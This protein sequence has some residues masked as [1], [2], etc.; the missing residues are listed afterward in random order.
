MTIGAPILSYYYLV[1]STYYLVPNTYYLSLFLPYFSVFTIAYNKSSQK[2]VMV[3]QLRPALLVQA[4][5]RVGDGKNL[6]DIKGKLLLKLR[7]LRL[8]CCFVPV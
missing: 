5:K 6:G 2:L 3:K 8:F 4:L 7:L 1:P